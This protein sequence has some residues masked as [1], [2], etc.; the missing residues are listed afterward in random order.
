MRE[1]YIDW[2]QSKIFLVYINDGVS[3]G[4]RLPHRLLRPFRHLRSSVTYIRCVAYTLRAL[5]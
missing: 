5:C 1:E 4:G 3:R 2:S